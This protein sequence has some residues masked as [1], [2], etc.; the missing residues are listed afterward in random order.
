MP[1]DEAPEEFADFMDPDV[2]WYVA[3]EF[4]ESFENEVRDLDG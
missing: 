1:E 2:R 3:N 4:I